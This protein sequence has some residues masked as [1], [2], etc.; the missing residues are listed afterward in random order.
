VTLSPV[1]RWIV[2]GAVTGELRW[3][4]PDKSEAVQRF[5]VVADQHPLASAMGTGSLLLGLF[6]LAYL[7]ST[8]RILRR[9]YRR[10]AA[11][12]TA[13]PLGALLGLAVW[14]FISAM[15][16]HELSLYIGIGSLVAG[17]VAASCALIATER[18]SLAKRR[19]A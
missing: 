1:A 17:A 8:A 10:P 13:L 9:G 11:R 12:Y 16:V 5:T 3:Q 15:T 6:A 7:E 19:T 18:A 2:G 4:R 14:T